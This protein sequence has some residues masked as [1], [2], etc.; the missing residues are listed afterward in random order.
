MQQYTVYLYLQTPLHVSGGISM[1]HQELI[2]LYLQYL[3]L[4]RPLLP[5]VVNVML[6]TGGSNGPSNA[7]Y[8]RYSDMSS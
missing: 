7:R 1:H 8:R 6:T 4:M 5:T 2:S 3:A